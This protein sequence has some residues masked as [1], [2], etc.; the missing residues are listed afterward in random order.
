MCHSVCANAWKKSSNNLKKALE[1]IK[2]Y[3]V[4][5]FCALENGTVAGSIEC[6]NNSWFH[7]AP[8]ISWLT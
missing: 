6:G 7:N 1:I 2:M 8:E 4:L 5:E 3:C